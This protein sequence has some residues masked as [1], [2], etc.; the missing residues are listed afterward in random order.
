MPGNESVSHWIGGVKD[1][2]SEAALELWNR[3]FERLVRAIHR[4]LRGQRRAASDEED[5]ALSVFESFCRAAEDGRFPDL[6]ERHDLWRLLLRMAARKVIDKRRHD[7]RQRRGGGRFIQSLNRDDAVIEV[8]GNEPSPELAAMMKE[9]LERLLSH[10]GDGPLR[11]IAIARLEGETNADIARRL[12][13]SERTVER[14]LHLI[15]EKCQQ[16]LT[17][18]D[19]QSTEQDDPSTGQP[20]GDAA[21]TP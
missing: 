18:D 13:C 6:R 5:I 11:D 10:L 8:I 19:D 12:K 17:S 15:R 2:D 1:G 21:G 20:E 4:D 14:R 7:R 16:E 9:S 3:Y